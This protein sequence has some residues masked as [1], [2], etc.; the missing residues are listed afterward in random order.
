MTKVGKREDSGNKPG[1]PLK[2]DK[3]RRDIRKLYRFS[4]EEY[5]IIQ[6]VVEASGI[7]ESKLVRQGALKEAHRLQSRK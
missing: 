4:I 7:E 6:A 1:I 3:V 5:S 2:S